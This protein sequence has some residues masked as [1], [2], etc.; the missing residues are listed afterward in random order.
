VALSGEADP[1][2]ELIDSMSFQEWLDHIGRILASGI[3][4]WDPLINSELADR[5]LT[6]TEKYLLDED[7]PLFGF[8]LGDP[9]YL[10]RAAVERARPGSE[11]RQDLSEVVAGGYYGLATKVAESS[12]QDLR[13]RLVADVPTVVLTEGRTDS[14]FLD[15]ALSILF[16]HLS[17]YYTFLDFESAGVM[18]GAGTL[19]GTV[20]SFV[21]ASIATVSS[22][23]LITTRLQPQRCVPYNA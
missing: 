7:R 12:R 1:E 17:D 5:T 19:V 21:A 9:R 2:Y 14:E 22:P 6:A 8:D 13:S 23:S 20:K 3:N 4:R 10:L 18:G 15:G 11:V 16:P